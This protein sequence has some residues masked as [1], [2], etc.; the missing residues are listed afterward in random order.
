M[1]I[2]DYFFLKY[3]VGVKLTPLPTPTP[4]KTTLE[5]PSLIRVKYS[6]QYLFA[7]IFIC[8]LLFVSLIC[9]HLQKYFL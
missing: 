1:L 5:K 2:L 7:V 3:E 8:Y 6:H 9:N 4:E